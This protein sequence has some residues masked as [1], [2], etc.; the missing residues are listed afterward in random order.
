[1]AH[2]IGSHERIGAGLIRLVRADLQAVRTGL[3]GNGP[4][5]R[6]IHRAR[7][8]LKRLRSML[9]VMKPALGAKAHIAKLKIREAAKRLAS[10]RDADAAAASARE[11]RAEAAGRTEAALDRLV[12]TLD[13]E[14]K[15]RHANAPPTAAVIAL[16]RAV[17]ADLADVADD[18]AGPD[19]LQK[20]LEH[21]YRRGRKALRRAES[22]LSMPDLHR[23][24]KDVKDLWHLMRLARE[25]L[26]AGSGRFAGKLEKLGELLG[27]DHDH[28]ILAV[29][30]VDA[31]PAEPILMHQLQM[32]ADKRRRL[33]GEAFALGEQLYR[34][35]PKRFSER[36]KL[37]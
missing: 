14:A 12:T 34:R 33:E 1:M 10:A 16:I 28:S 23:W 3:A 7:Q 22:S 31:P 25:R 19:L 11:L 18:M 4:A 30:L 27:L 29:K 35:A 17:E 5:D 8:R 13:R 26:P 20:A 24:R 32:I 9:R 6:R 21:S 15:V 36:L 37:E 2:K